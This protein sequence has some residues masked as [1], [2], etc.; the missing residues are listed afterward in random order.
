MYF[1]YMSVIS[2]RQATIDKG[3]CRH[4]RLSTGGIRYHGR[5]VRKHEYPAAWRRVRL[6]VLERDGWVCQIK[7]PKCAGKADAVDH[8]LP[9][10]AGGHPLHPDNLR[11]C[12]TGCNTRRANAAAGDRPSRLW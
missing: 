8:I 4:Y 10:S 3:K 6:A 2:L 5:V 11:A 7:L 1:I 12:C 9:V